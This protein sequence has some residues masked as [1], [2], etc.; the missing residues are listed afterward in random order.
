M[1]SS[2]DFLR[3][4]LVDT[5]RSCDVSTARDLQEIAS[6]LE[7]E[8]DSFL[9]ITLPNFAKEFERAL[10]E[11]KVATN[12]FSGFKRD[13]RGGHLPAFL[14]GFVSL[15]F[16][17]ETGTLKDTPSIAAIQAVRQVCLLYSK[18]LLPCNIRRKNAAFRQYIRTEQE[19]RQA[20]NELNGDN[21]RARYLAMCLVLWDSYL[22]VC[23]RK[24]ALEGVPFKHGPGAT[25][26]DLFGNAKFGQQ[27][28]TERLD[29]E[30]PHWEAGTLVPNE[31][32]LDRLNSVTVLPPGAETPVRVVAVP[33]TLKTP[34]I[35]A[36]EPTCMQYVQQG[37]AGL[38]ARRARVND[39]ANAFV[40]SD[41]Q[42]P[43]QLLAKKGSSDGSL[44]TLDLSE[45]SDR[46]SNQHVRLLLSRYPNLFRA[47]DACRSRKAD[48]PDHGV[49]RLAKFASMGSALTFPLEAMV[50]TTVAFLGIERA[51]GR[52]LTHRDVK[53]LMG[54]VRVY[55]DD[56]IVPVGYVNYV[57]EELEAFGFRVNTHKSFWTGKFRES[58]GAEFFD[59]EDVSVVRQRR[60]FP[61]S[62]KDAKSLISTI[63]F[64]NLL[65]WRG[66][67][68]SAAYV[69]NLLKDLRVPMPIVKSTSAIVGRESVFDYQPKRIHR[70]YQHPLV[71]GLV[72]DAKPPKQPLED[73][74]AL[75]KWFISRGEEPT[76]VDLLSCSG[77]PRTVRLKTRWKTP[78]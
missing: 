57:I 4:L 15:V 5:G 27:R 47:V 8:G 36:L 43:N 77:R 48:V 26:D 7:H 49:I 21:R 76:E 58:C 78:Y 16:D 40:R 42:L 54:R 38:L 64:R 66:L 3:C 32:F 39:N 11:G 34:R 74:G 28:W 23:E 65:Y 51:V 1:K 17:A 35:I 30:F 50:F 63:E 2:I 69:D 22:R 29:K 70:R 12:S 53:R 37:L 60:I 25:A 14:Q 6:R 68:A 33:K 10:D 72:V 52:Q 20:D 18:I 19:V 59:G 41:S 45:A 46:V 73:Y 13:R 71:K 24:L 62:R 67:W 56:I 31:H 9:T 44:A 55:G 75:M 61:K